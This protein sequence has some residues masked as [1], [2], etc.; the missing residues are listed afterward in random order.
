MSPKVNWLTARFRYTVREGMLFFT[1]LAA[2]DKTLA[3][4]IV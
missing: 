1:A 2:T 3:I 4:K